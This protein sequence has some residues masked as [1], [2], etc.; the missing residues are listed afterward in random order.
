MTLPVDRRPRPFQQ[1]LDECHPATFG[2]GNK[3]VLDETY[4]KAGQMDTE[5]FCTNS[6]PYE[7]GVIDTIVQALAC[8]GGQGSADYR[9]I[10]AQLYKLNARLSLFLSLCV[11]FSPHPPIR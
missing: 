8:S 6:T 4:R 9:G 5:R 11:L 3:D 2:K 1:L 7:H 10:R